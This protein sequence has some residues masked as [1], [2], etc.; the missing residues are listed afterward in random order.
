MHELFNVELLDVVSCIQ[1]QPRLKVRLRRREG[2]LESHDKEP[3]G[4][5]V[6]EI[7]RIRALRAKPLHVAAVH[8]R[9]DE[10]HHAEDEKRRR[11]KQKSH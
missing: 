11:E 7:V 9:K 3:L 8:I 4:H 5:G 2:A 10:D 1:N 6:K